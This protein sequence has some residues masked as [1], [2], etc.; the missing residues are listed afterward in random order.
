[1][2]SWTFQNLWY[3]SQYHYIMISYMISCSGARFQMGAGPGPRQSSRSRPGLSPGRA[4]RSL[5]LR[6]IERSAVYIP[7][8]S[9]KGI[10]NVSYHHVSTSPEWLCAYPEPA[11]SST[12]LLIFLLIMIATVAEAYRNLALPFQ[13]WLG[14]CRPSHRRGPIVFAKKSWQSI[15]G[16]T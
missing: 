7:Q 5:D 1:M 2:I 10:T 14:R 3:H 13:P 16:N 8:S 6:A 11:D 4:E 15:C 9:Q 12:V